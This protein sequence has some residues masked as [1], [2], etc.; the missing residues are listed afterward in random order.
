[1]GLHT[2]AAELRD[3]DY[4]GPALN[5]AARLMAAAHGGQIVC[6]Q[7][8]ADLVR[9]SL[10]DDLRLVD[11]GEHRL[12]D[13]VRPEWVFQLTHPDLIAEFPPLQSLGVGVLPGNLPVRLSSFVGRGQELDALANALEKSRLVTITGVGGV[14]KT[15]LAVQGAVELADS[16]A[17]GAWLCELAPAADAGALVQVVAATLGVNER[18]GMD[19]EASITDF[20]R[21][22]GLLLVLD[23]CEQL[24]DAVASMVEAVLQGAPGV[25]VIA[26]SR[27]ALGIEGERGLPLRPLSLPAADELDSVVASDAVALFCERAEAV[28]PGFVVDEGNAAVVAE[29]CA[30]LD[31]IPLAIELAA[32]RVGVMGVGEIGALLDQRFRAH[33][34]SA[35]GPSSDVARRGGLVLLVTRGA[36]T[37]GVRAVGRVRGEF[38]C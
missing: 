22:K 38:R 8:T 15:R 20:L 5:R 31:G 11:L 36:G 30:R 24:V 16:Y 26:T 17:D 35:L 21:R 6:S 27:E 2:G 34:G 13:L 32:A 3:G 28:V 37:A 25:R 12:R 29:I 18:P 4:Y 10:P 33:G 19:L 9:D 7:V 14:G 1:M 23:N